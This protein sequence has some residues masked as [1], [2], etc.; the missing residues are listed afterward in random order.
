MTRGK[1]WKKWTM[2]EFQEFALWTVTVFIIRE[3]K[4]RQK[5]RQDLRT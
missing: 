4:F 2:E 1:E 5:R 3:L